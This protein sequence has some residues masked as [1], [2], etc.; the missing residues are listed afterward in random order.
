MPLA[1]F[2]VSFPLPP[3]LKPLIQ[4]DYLAALFME[5]EVQKKLGNFWRKE[6]PIWG[7]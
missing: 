3:P 4:Q 6:L 5:M 2:I 1:T 7:K